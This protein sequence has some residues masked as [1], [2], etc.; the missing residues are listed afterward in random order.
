MTDQPTA[1]P[2]PIAEA[3]P[4]APEVATEETAAG[5]EVYGAAVT[6]GAYT[7]FVADF[8]DTDT[9]WEAYE[10]LKAMEDGA[11][12]KIEGVVVVK[13]DAD[14]EVKVQ[15]ATD[16]AARRGLVWGLV[17]GAVLG[18][19]FPPS[20]I[21]SAAALGA[22]GAVTGEVVKAHRRHE[23]AEQ[24]EIDQAI[25]PG[26]SAIIALASDPGEVQIR[27]ALAAANAI[28]ATTVDSVTARDLK[29]AA[30]AAEAE[31][32]QASTEAEAAPVAADT[33]GDEAPK[34]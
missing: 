3:A 5:A 28:V 13:R 23:L 32:E 34:A 12:V 30:K 20:I 26:H 7:L 21:G 22:A 19:I 8:P 24:L 33:A 27:K 16:H 2:Q 1:D 25:E 4:E 18:I 10:A 31:A 6:D 9:A 15:K 29:A 17:G 11:T 14:G